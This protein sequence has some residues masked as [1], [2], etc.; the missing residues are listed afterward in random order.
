[1]PVDSLAKL[2]RPASQHIEFMPQDLVGGFSRSGRANR[3][4]VVSQRYPEALG[5]PGREMLYRGAP[6]AEPWAQLRG[7]RLGNPVT[8]AETPQRAVDQ[9]GPSKASQQNRRPPP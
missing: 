5:I 6:N 3:S 7:V 4:G 2:H 9:P 8:I 1:M